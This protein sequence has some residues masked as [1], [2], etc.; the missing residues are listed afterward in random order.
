MLG[1]TTP[2]KSFPYHAI[3]IP[4]N[5]DLRADRQLMTREHYETGIKHPFFCSFVVE[6]ATKNNID[7]G[8]HPHIYKETFENCKQIKT[9][10]KLTLIGDTLIV[11]FYCNYKSI[12]LS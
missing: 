4:K 11:L 12:W 7:I 3:N 1:Q 8:N 6:N 10:L 9:E 5:V 2:V